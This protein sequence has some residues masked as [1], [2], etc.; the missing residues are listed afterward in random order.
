RSRRDDSQH[1]QDPPRTPGRNNT[2]QTRE[3]RKDQ[4]VNIPR[5]RE[6]PPPTPPSRQGDH[7]R[8]D[9]R[10]R[11]RV[12]VPDRQEQPS[13]RSGPTRERLPGPRREEDRKSI[14]LNSSHV[15]IS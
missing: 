14:R 15:S 1:P 3:R 4:E 9:A 5:Q 2:L 8:R 7:V 10:V 11:E 6:Q 12:R 13:T